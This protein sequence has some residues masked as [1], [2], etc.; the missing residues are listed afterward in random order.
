ME[1]NMEATI[2][3]WPFGLA[4]FRCIHS[5]L[6]RLLSGPLGWRPSSCSI[7]V[8]H[9]FDPLGWRAL[10]L[11]LC[12]S[13]A[14]T[15]I[16]PPYPGFTPH[17]PSGRAPSR[18]LISYLLHLFCPLVPAPPFLLVALT[19]LSGALGW[20]PRGIVGRC[21]GVGQGISKETSCASRWWTSNTYEERSTK[22][23]PVPWPFCPTNS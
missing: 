14:Y 20:R 19:S 3:G 13:C 22:S 2:S 17:W 7:L 6:F 21:V 8:L 11:S 23:L 1:K 16:F 12:A 18:P 15:S 9:L 10:F 4:L 5:C